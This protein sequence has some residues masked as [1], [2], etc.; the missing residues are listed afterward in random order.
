MKMYQYAEN[1]L[2]SAQNQYSIGQ[3]KKNFKKHFISILCDGPTGSV[4]VQKEC[5]YVFFA[6]P[7]NFHLTILFLSHRDSSSQDTKM[8]I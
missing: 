4:V 2:T 1:L 6:D 3:L 8:H 7:E 5:V